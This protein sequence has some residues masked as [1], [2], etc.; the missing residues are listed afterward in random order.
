MITVSELNEQIK[1]TLE[2]TF[3]HIVV[4]GEVS[5]AT[6]HSSGHLYF[7]IKDEK[8][9]L[10][11]VMWRSSVKKLKFQVEVGEHIVIDGSIGV[12]TP[13][14]EY[15]LIATNIEPFGKGS[16][17][18]AFEQLKK[19]LEKKGYFDKSLKKELPTIPNKIAVITALKSA[20]LQDILNVTKKRWPLVELIVID[21][22][23]Q[24]E[25]AAAQIAKAIE[26]ADTLDADIILLARGGGSQEDLWA[27]NEEIV[28][29]AIFSAKTPVVSAIGHEVDFLISDFV[30]DLRAPTPS[31]AMEIILP[32]I[33]ELLYT[34]SSMEDNIKD[35]IDFKLL[36]AKESIDALYQK[37]A[38]LSPIKKLEFLIEQFK[39][40]HIN[41]NDTLEYKLKLLSSQIEPIETKLQNQIEHILIKKGNILENLQRALELNNPNNR[42]K[43]GFVE[44]LKDKK[45]VSLCDIKPND[46]IYLVDSKCK[47]E[48]LALKKSYF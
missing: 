19:K 44:V 24:G 3:M 8:S 17:S 43:P 31:A 42:V 11:C 34:L 41:L 7:S 32:D 39:R 22:L 47:L 29:D 45:R 30:A 28:A 48:V 26:F 15:Q 21:T 13:R 2:T 20:A 1:A 25:L 4:Q 37:M 27:F 18:V 6:Y 33:N 38:L 46:T 40:V 16:L 12:Y 5:S 35:I 14:G 36:R 9:T 23:T 10:K